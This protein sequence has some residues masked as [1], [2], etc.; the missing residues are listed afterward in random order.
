M[1]GGPLAATAK[2]KARRG[3]AGPAGL[4]GQKTP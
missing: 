3:G 1:I 2:A 4:P